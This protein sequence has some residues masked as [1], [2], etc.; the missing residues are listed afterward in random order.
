MK[1]LLTITATPPKAS[2]DALLTETE[3]PTREVVS[4]PAAFS[5]AR[6][7]LPALHGQPQY[8]FIPSNRPLWENPLNDF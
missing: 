2:P 8:C 5:A 6:P 4:I 7:T 1:T 3:H